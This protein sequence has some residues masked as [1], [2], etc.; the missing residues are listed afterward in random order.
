MAGFSKEFVCL[1]FLQIC[2][3]HCIA[4]RLKSIP[5]MLIKL[6][7]SLPYTFDQGYLLWIFLDIRIKLVKSA[8]LRFWGF[9]VCLDFVIP[10]QQAVGFLAAASSVEWLDWVTCSGFWDL[11]LGL[12]TPWV[13]W[14]EW[15][16]WFWDFLRFC[17]SCVT[18]RGSSAGLLYR[19]AEAA[20]WFRLAAEE[21]PIHISSRARYF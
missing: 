3:T 19:M 2:D 7:F 17:D 6:F 12:M 10:Q 15:S 9:G 5:D 16:N 8:L 21:M 1:G 18:G 13:G 20:V 14:L 11:C 4:K